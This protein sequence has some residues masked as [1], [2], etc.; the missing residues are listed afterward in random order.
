MFDRHRGLRPVD[1]AGDLVAGHED[2][3]DLQVAMDE[4]GCPRPERSRGDR[5]VAGDDVAGENV[6]GEEPLAFAVE[7]RREFIDAPAWPYRQWRV[8][9]GSDRGTCGRPRSRRRRGCLAEVAER[10]AR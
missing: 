5:A 4:Y 1:D 8:V 3:V 9:K 2:V 10:G 7:V 6:V